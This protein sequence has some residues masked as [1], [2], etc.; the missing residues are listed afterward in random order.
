MSAFRLVFWPKKSVLFVWNK[1]KNSFKIDWQYQVLDK[2]F[3]DEDA[4]WWS[5]GI[6]DVLKNST[7]T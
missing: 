7:H 5:P 4:S 1:K 2:V 3:P 6:V